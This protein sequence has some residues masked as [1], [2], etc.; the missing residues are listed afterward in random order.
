M[1]DGRWSMVVW[2]GGRS[3]GVMWIWKYAL[4]SSF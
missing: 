1:G 2:G 4:A 3:V